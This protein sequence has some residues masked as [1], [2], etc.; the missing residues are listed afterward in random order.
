MTTEYRPRFTFEISDEQQERAGRL[1]VTHGQR[2]S[3]M[4]IVLDDLLDLLEEHGQIIAGLILDKAV[5]PREV[6]PVLAKA[7]RRAKG[8]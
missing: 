4:S 1:F 7:E 5:R 2:K 8:E 3:V 6:I